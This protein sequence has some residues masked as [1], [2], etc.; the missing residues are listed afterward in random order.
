MRTTARG[1][2]AHPAPQQPRWRVGA[3]TDAAEAAA[4]AVAARVLGTRAV[5]PPAMA[6]AT[7]GVIRRRAASGTAQPGARAAVDA[8]LAE[9]GVPLARSDA[10]FFGAGMAADFSPVRVHAGPAADRAA[11]SV[12]ARAFALGQHLV[13]AHGEYRPASSEGRR[14]LAHELAHVAQGATG[15]GGSADGTATL[16]RF[17]RSEEGEIGTLDEVIEEARSRAD[18]SADLPGMMSW[19]RFT[20]ANGGQALQEFAAG[21]AGVVR[22]FNG[23]PGA[24]P[25]AQGGAAPSPRYLFTCLCGLVDMR[26]FYQLM[27]IALITGNF[28]AVEEGRAHEERA[29]ASSRFAPEDTPSNA[30]GAYFGSQQSVFQRQSVFVANLRAHLARCHP[31][32]YRALPEDQRGMILDWYAGDG[33]SRP[34]HQNE[35]AYPNMERIPACEGLGM[36]PFVLAR[37]NAGIT[38][39]IVGTVDE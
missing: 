14:L 36:F 1:A 17:M 39:R 10:A 38:N 18:A 28:D 12:G 22:E 32:D 6:D 34:A 24:G 4:D 7:A 15:Q 8:A 23:G 5:H 31:I 11:R 2:E 21:F 37:N 19:G 20:A 25:S 35:Q 13:F 33:T 9:P 26:H 29:V 30:L 16:R 3:P 27:Y